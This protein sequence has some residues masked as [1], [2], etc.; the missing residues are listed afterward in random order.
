MSAYLVHIGY[1]LMLVALLAR[2][3]LWLRGLLVCAQSTLAVYAWS[4][5]A[6]GMT[7]WNVLFVLINTVWVIRILRERRAVELPPD[8]RALHHRHFAALTPP[9][10]LRWW[11]QGRRETLRGASLARSGE[12]PESLFFVLAGTVRVSHGDRRVT[13]LGPGFFVAEMS[14]LTGEPA[15]ADAVAVGD[16]DVMR[17]PADELRE[18]KARKPAIWI[19]I[20]SVLGHDLVEKIGARAHTA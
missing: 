4:I 18:I 11:R 19:K 17:W 1:A 5:G 8:L 12:F 14:L 10:F 3:I 7:A 2:D 15:T 13:D 16:V 6:V 9:E 20:Q